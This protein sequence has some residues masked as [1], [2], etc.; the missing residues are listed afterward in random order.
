MAI[1][2]SGAAQQILMSHILKSERTIR[3]ESGSVNEVHRHYR[4]HAAAQASE[5]VSKVE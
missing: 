3:L 4:S 1:T 5:F 2:A